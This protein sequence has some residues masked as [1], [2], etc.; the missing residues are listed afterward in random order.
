MLNNYVPLLVLFVLAF[1]FVVV[2]V[3]SAALA[4]WCGPPPA[5]AR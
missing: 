2:S 5:G 1:G 4:S 3:V